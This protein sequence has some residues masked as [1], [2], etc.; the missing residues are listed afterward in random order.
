MKSTSCQCDCHRGKK[1]LH[2]IDCC[3]LAGKEVQQE[4]RQEAKQ[5]DK[6]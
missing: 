1:L 6:K 5:E 4:Q 2:I 3:A